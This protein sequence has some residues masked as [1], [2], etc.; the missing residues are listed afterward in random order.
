MGAS[1]IIL[2][3]FLFHF[4]SLPYFIASNENCAKNNRCSKDKHVIS[5]PFR[6]KGCQGERCGYPGFDLICDN[7][8]RTVLDLP[9]SE[10]F[11]VNNIIYGSTFNEIELEDPDNC[12]A[13]RLLNQLNLSGTP[14]IG[15]EYQNYSFFSCQSHIY[16]PVK[17]ISCLG[18][19]THR[20]FA[21]A[22]STSTSSSLPR[23]NCTLIATVPVPVLE[24]VSDP[25]EY[26]WFPYTNVLHLTWNWKAPYWKRNCNKK[27]NFL[28]F[29]DPVV[30]NGIGNISLIVIGIV[31][32]TVIATVLCYMVFT[33]QG[34]LSGGGTGTELTNYSTQLVTITTGLDGFAVPSFP[35]IVVAE[36]ERL[37]NPDN[38]T[39]SICLSEYQP[40]ETL[41]TLPACNHC[42]HVECIDVWLRLNSTCPVCRI[43]PA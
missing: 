3:F 23:A 36:G 34:F 29:R 38:D 19:S 13:G 42:F 6:M 15:I 21:T 11:F 17:N 5:Y 22:Y 28:S 37:P 16:D 32:P 1:I 8:N 26:P 12:L 31:I 4:L 33:S 24:Y 27:S 2:P 35:T 14:F 20:V 40:K 41:K 7:M 43:S 18:N 39:C 10:P 25:Y 30:P 9:F